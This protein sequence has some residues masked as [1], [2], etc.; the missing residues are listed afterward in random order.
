MLNGH[1]FTVKGHAALGE[2]LTKFTVGWH[3]DH[4]RLTVEGDFQFHGAFNHVRAFIG[5]TCMVLVLINVRPSRRQVDVAAQ[6]HYHGDVATV[7]HRSIEQANGDTATVGTWVALRD[8]HD[9]LTG[10]DAGGPLKG[11]AVHG[12]ADRNCITLNASNRVQHDGRI[13]Q[14]VSIKLV[15]HRSLN[16]NEAGGDFNVR[17]IRAVVNGVAVLVLRCVVDRLE[18]F[19][20]DGHVVHITDRHKDSPNTFIIGHHG[21]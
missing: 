10:L 1:E 12:P 21:G 16:L 18:A 5:R 3:I 14:A 20:L 8:H 17:G 9:P 11:G 4:P 6:R 19:L 13:H 15:G 7:G 2:Q